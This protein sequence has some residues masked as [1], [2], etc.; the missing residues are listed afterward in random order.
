MSTPYQP[1][2]V[3]LAAQKHWQE[4]RCFEV[5]E[6]ADK[7]K[8]YC[9][10]MF[11]YPSGK[12][13][14][15]HVRVLTISDVIARFQRMQGK[16]VMQPMGFDAFGMPAENAAIKHGV[17]PAKCGWSV[18]AGKVKPKAAGFLTIATSAISRGT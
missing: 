2:M 5:G 13:H 7:E 16:H 4:S 17:P 15:G 1:E 12:L 10:T 14:M 6:D 11:P 3:E 18:I 9:L 8:F